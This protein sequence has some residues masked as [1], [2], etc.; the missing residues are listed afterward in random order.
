MNSVDEQKYLIYQRQLRSV[1]SQYERYRASVRAMIAKGVKKPVAQVSLALV[2][3]LVLIAALGI[4]VLRPT[5]LTVSS[6]MKE[7]QDEQRLVTALDDKFRSLVLVEGLMEEMKLELPRIDWA[8]PAG[9]EFEVFAKEVEILAK[10]K[11][12]SGVEISQAGFEMTEKGGGGLAAGVTVGG[13]EEQV[14]NFLA[15][16]IKMDRL[17]LLKSVNVSSV[18]GDQRQDEPYPVMMS[19]TVEILYSSENSENSENSES[20]KVGMSENQT[21]RK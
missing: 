8:I 21:I 15:D 9:Q 6:L 16:L 14:R 13:N 10:E 18:S 3:T 7:I 20:Q 19:A 12:L 17:V 1:M 2:G 4:L 5:L 11:G